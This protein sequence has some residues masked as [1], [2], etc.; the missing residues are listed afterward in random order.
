MVKE[1]PGGGAGGGGRGLKRGGI[2]SEE[3]DGALAA[4]NSHFYQ[5]RLYRTQGLTLTFFFLL[6][7]R[8]GW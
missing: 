8:C 2:M 4:D 1:G 7:S 3:E 5:E 6:S